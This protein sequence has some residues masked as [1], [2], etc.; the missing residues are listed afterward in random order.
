MERAEKCENCRFSRELKYGFEVGKGYKKGLC[1][2][3]LEL[4]EGHAFIME[5]SPDGYCE[6]YHK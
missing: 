3:A 1:C 5:V 2:I 4:L 6:E